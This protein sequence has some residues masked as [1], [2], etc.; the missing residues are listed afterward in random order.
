MRNALL[1]LF[2]LL[3]L[4]GCNAKDSKESK[5][6]EEAYVLHK[7]EICL[8]NLSTKQLSALEI[9]NKE[10]IRFSLSPKH[11]YIAYLQSTHRDDCV[12]FASLGIYDIEKEC[13]I[14]VLGSEKYA[15]FYFERWV[16]DST[17]VYTMGVSTSP[18]EYKTGDWSIAS[19]LY[20]AGHGITKSDTE[21]GDPGSGP[22]PISKNDG[23]LTYDGEDGIHLLDKQ[24]QITKIIRIEG[25]DIIYYKTVAWQNPDK[26]VFL[27]RRR[28]R[29]Q[30]DRER[31]DLYC[32]DLHADQKQLLLRDVTNVEMIDE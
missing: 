9:S 7:G 11:D 1:R 8:C 28:Y 21:W 29:H 31:A 26:F 13:T 3:F 19:Y 4:L 24:T 5:D 10:I 27:A 14:A 18:D 20:T 23:F 25:D 2:S 30:C 12:E 22:R 32:Y 16:S 17:F 15:S 6:T